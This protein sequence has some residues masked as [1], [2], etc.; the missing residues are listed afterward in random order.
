MISYSS[1][2]SVQS[3]FLS[4]EMEN[5]SC[6]VFLVPYSPLASRVWD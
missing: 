3:F 4:A 1:N 2:V 6:Q 5:S